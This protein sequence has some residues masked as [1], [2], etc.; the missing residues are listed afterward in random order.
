MQNL[1][2]SYASCSYKSLSFTDYL[3]YS[4]KHWCSKCGTPIPASRLLQC[5]SVTGSS[6]ESDGEAEHSEEDLLTKQKRKAHQVATEIMTSEEEFFDKL[7]LL[8][9]VGFKL[10]MLYLLAKFDHTIFKSCYIILFHCQQLVRCHI[11]ALC[12]WFSCDVWEY[13][14]SL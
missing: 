6:S 11:I 5:Y 7:V 9:I 2:H 4:S 8:N 13:T 1:D 12:V 10:Y 3:Q 14:Y